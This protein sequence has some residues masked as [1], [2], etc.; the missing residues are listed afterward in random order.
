MK[1]LV[2]LDMNGKKILNTSFDLKFRDIFKV[3]NCYVETLPQPQP[4]FKGLLKRKSD[5]QIVGFPKPVALHAIIIKKTFTSSNQYLVIR[6]RG[7]GEDARIF[8]NNFPRTTLEIFEYG[9]WHFR[10]HGTGSQQI[11]VIIAVSDF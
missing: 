8:L 4:K 9:I 7:L 3:I 5:N 1:M 2:P 6:S 11:D 10:F